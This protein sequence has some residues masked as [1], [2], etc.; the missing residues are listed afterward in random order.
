MPL[1][2]LTKIYE[3]RF[4]FGKADGVCKDCS[5]F[6]RIH[7]RTKTYSKCKVYG[8]SMSSATD[9]SG[10]KPSLRHV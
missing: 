9:W 2:T 1:R 7:Y 6:R 4:R 3:M 8:I 5:N 10:K